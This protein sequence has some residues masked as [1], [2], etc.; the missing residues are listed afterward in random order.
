MKKLLLLVLSIVCV[1][2]GMIM[3]S[4][5]QEL[6]TRVLTQQERAEKR[7]ERGRYARQ[8]YRGLLDPDRDKIPDLVAK[9]DR[10]LNLTTEI[11]MPTLTPFA[12]PP[13]AKQ[14]LRDRSCDV[15]AVIIGVVRSQTS[16][17]TEDET[18]IYTVNEIEVTTVL[19][20]NV[21]QSIKAGDHISVLRTG[22]TVEIN[23]R[24]VTAVYVASLGLEMDRT[25]LLFM[26][27]IPEKGVY[28]ADS[29]SHELRNDKIV[30]LR[31]G[32]YSERELKTGNDASSYVA[33]VRTAVA[34]PCD[35]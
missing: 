1:C 18:F 17:L 30:S 13:T 33:L 28:V 20:D 6:K 27:F 2:A 7:R 11:G 34:A 23:G 19:K 4:S 12:K 29:M 10:D 21:A 15:D 22:G 31:R 16:R 8:V 25:Y 24:K 3:V 5:S 26:M 32:G 9:W 14:I 35:D